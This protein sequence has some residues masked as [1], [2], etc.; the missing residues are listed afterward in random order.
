MEDFGLSQLQPHHTL[1]PPLLP[2]QVLSEA[3]ALIGQLVEDFGLSQLP[4]KSLLEWA[5]EDLTSANAGV[6]NAVIQ[7]LGVMHRCGGGRGGRNAA[8]HAFT[9]HP[10]PFRH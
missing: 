6:R 7:A 3:F 1:S 5:K 8:H 2:W 10:S 4:V 9:R